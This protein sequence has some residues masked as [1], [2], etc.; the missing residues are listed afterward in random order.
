MAPASRKV[1]P[2]AEQSA[3]SNGGDTRQ[4]G[5]KAVATA[6]G[7]GHRNRVDPND[8]AGGERAGL[9]LGISI[10]VLGFLGLAASLAASPSQKH[11]GL[12]QPGTY[13]VC[14]AGGPSIYTVDNDNS[15]V[16]CISIAKNRI[17]AVGSLG[18]IRFK[19]Y[20]SSFITNLLQGSPQF[21]LPVHYIPPGAIVIPGISDSHAHILEFGATQQLPLEGTKSVEETVARV[22]NFVLSNADIFE[23]KTKLITG[24]GW[25]HTSWPN[26]TL[27]SLEALENDP[28]LR[29]RPI[30]L[31]SKDCHALWVSSAALKPSLPLPDEVEGGVIVRDQNNQPTGV[32]LDNAQDLLKQPKLTQEDLLRRFK[33]TVREAHKHGLTSI[34]DAGL[35]PIS[36]EFFHSQAEKAPLPIRIYGMKYFNETVGYSPGSYPI[37]LPEKRLSIRSMKIFA[38]GALRTGGAALY[39]PYADNPSTSG[40]M[41][42]EKSLLY[43]VIPKFLSN[44]WQVNVHAIGDKANGIIL[45]VFESALKGINVTALRPR[46]EHAQMMTKEDMVRLG[47]LGVIASVQPTHA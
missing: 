40:F 11:V 24:G 22:R 7:K 19:W 5:R 39:E 17:Q 30:I 32:L 47:K 34:H 25:D 3:A 45:D 44:G 20:T 23:D 14:S 27:P 21:H 38:D 9:S 33:V 41:R 2:T 13:A 29:G 46:L 10:A 6:N 35:D 1:A 28:I 16:A 43:D 42:I 36:L 26:G 8:T 18:H 15:R 12:A 4:N 31:Q 37:D